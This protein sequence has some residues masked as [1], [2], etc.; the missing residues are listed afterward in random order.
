MLKLIKKK[1][2]ESKEGYN[3]ILKEKPSLGDGSEIDVDDEE[4]RRFE[5]YKEK[6]TRRKNWKKK[7]KKK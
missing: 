5:K 2:K 6:R 3:K 7:K 4:L 1:K